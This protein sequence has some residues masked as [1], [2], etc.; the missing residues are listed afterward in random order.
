MH[1]LSYL[2]IFA[3]AL[4]LSLLL[5]RVIT[6]LAVRRGLVYAPP[7]DRH[8]HREPVPRL[9]GIAIFLSSMG[10]I[11]GMVL[12]APLA[13]IAQPVPTRMLGLISGTA[14]IIFLLG[15]ADDLW[16]V[17]PRTKFA[18]QAI[19]GVLLYVGGF[20]VLHMHVLFGHRD[21]GF[22]VGLLITV[23]WVLLITNAFNLLDGLDGLA[24]GS[25]G[26]A[27]LTMFA[28][29]LING[30]GPMAL[31]IAALAGAIVG[32]LPS[33]FNPAKIFM[34]DCGSLFLGFMLSAVALPTS[35]KSPTL[36]AV[37]IPLVSFGL[38]L[39]DTVLSIMRRF[40]SGKPLFSADREHIHH[41]L[42][43]RGLSHR[44]AVLVLYL[45][46]CGFAF[47]SLLILNGAIVGAVLAVLAIGVFV[48]VQRLRYK[49]FAELLRLAQRTIEQKQI[50]AN[51]I[52]IRRAA[53]ELLHAHDSDSVRSTLVTAFQHN[54]FDGFEVSYFAP[55]NAG[56]YEFA[57]RWERPATSTDLPRCWS[58][59][60]DLV[61]SNR[62]QRGRLTVYKSLSNPLRMDI[63]CL[64]SPEFTIALADALERSFADA[65]SSYSEPS[66]ASL[67]AS[68]VV[69]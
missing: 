56:P 66:L 39:L 10:V 5:T 1:G 38:P 34:G 62:E 49:E 58:M 64:T 16:S 18:V 24:A 43:R 41:R 4:V 67:E 50:M 57:Y 46:C 9:G 37:A 65:G 29:H 17:K 63:N 42:L 26:F 48:F 13:G 14:T 45:V 35:Q 12:L 55:A 59:Q 31:T 27:T 40:L 3:S 22:S 68:P 61:C 53:E 52:A 47:F 8:V 54:E 21:L 51:N 25:A 11:W 32:F 7:S 23:F 20:R 2:A 6:R 28:V 60:V 15:L 33:N 19:A 36:I 69:Q 44:E 30:N